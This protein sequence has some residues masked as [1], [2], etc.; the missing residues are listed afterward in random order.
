[1]KLIEDAMLAE[2]KE[3]LPRCLTIAD[4]YNFYKDQFHWKISKEITND[5]HRTET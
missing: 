3:E 2:T 1:M 5:L 4:L